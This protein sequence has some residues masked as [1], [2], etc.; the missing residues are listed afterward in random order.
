MKLRKLYLVALCA[1]VVTASVPAL[2]FAAE[3]ITAQAPTDSSTHY[4]AK[5]TTG[6]TIDVTV[7]TTGEATIVTK[8][9]DS[10][11][12]SSYTTDS[13]DSTDITLEKISTTDKKVTI[14]SAIKGG[15]G[16]TYTVKTIGDGAF[17]NAK[18]EKVAFPSTVKTVEENAFAGSALKNVNTKNTDTIGAGAFKDC[19][20]MTKATTS[21]TKVGAGAFKNSGLKKLTYKNTSGNTE[22]AKG[23]FGGM[24]KG[25]KVVVKTTSKAQFNSIKSDI[26]KAGGKKLNIT[27]KKVKK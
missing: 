1:V 16:T 6:G 25:T 4:E 13:A 23:A 24:K 3:S 8:T 17:K 19:K 20:K 7:E 26:E 18:V 27:F 10:S 9:A 5:D 15:N 21:A 14:P 12:M 22:F 11:S 2:S